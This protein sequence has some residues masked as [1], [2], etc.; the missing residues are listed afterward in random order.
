MVDDITE[1]KKMEDELKRH[2]EHLKELVEERTGKIVEGEERF[3]SVADHA[4]EA[5]ITIDNHARIVFWNRAAESIFGY[6]A[7]EATGKPITLI[8]PIWARKNNRREIRDR[9]ASDET[10]SIGKTFEVVGLRKDG[11]EFP[12]EF[13]FSVWKTRRGLFSTRI[14]RDISER[15]KVQEALRESERRYRNLVETAPEVIYTISSDGVLTSL[16]PAFE[17]LT[18]WK[19]SEWLGKPFAA[20]VHPDDLPL[21]YETFQETMRGNTPPLYELRV[22]SKSGKYLVGEFTSGPCIENGRIVGE[23]GVVRDITERKK[24]EE[25]LRASEE[26]F[27]SLFENVLVGVFQTSPEGTIITANPMLVRLFGYDSL[28]EFLA[29]D[30][31]RDLYVNPQDRKV[32]R[33]QLEEGGELHSVELALKRKDGQ[34][35]IVLESVH[36]V[37]DEHG[38]VSYYE[39]T[40]TDITERKTLEERLSALNF[41]SGKLNTSR[42]LQQIYELTLDAMERMLGFENAAFMTVER[43]RLQGVCQRGFP[44]PWLDLPLDGSKKGITVKAVNTRKPVL[45]YDVRR[46]RDYAEANPKIRSEL[47]VPVLVKDRVLGVLD[48][49]GTRAGAFDEKDLMLLQILASH[50]AIAISNLEQRKE[51]EKR[52]SQMAVLMKSSAE[53]IHSLD[54]RYRLQKIA[55]SIKEHGWRRV[56]IRAVDEASME[57]TNPQDMVTAGL[58]AKERRFL[59]NSRVPGQVWRERIGPEFERFRI[60]EFFYLPWSNPWVRRRFSQGTVASHLK[61]E[62]MVDWDPEDLLYAPLRLADGRVVGVLSVDDPTDGRKPT[63][64]SLAP[65]ELFLHQAAVAIENAQLF[66]QLTEAK[67]QIKEYADQLELKVKQRTQELVEAQHKLLKTERLATIGEI[68]A[69]VG[70]DLRNPLTGIAGAIYYLRMKSGSADEKSKEMLEIIERDV[71]YSNKIV[72]DLLDYSREIHLE[73]KEATMKAILTEA[74]SLVKIPPSVR[75]VDLTRNWPKANVDREKLKR[76]VVNLIKNAVDAMPKGGTLTVESRKA[77]EHLEVTFN[78]TGVGMSQEVIKK[79]WSPLFT[80][81]AKG[82]GF[83]LAI[84]KR[85]IEAHGGSIFVKSSIGKGTTFTITVPIEAKVEAE[86]G[87]SVWVNVPESLLSTMM[88]L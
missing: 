51:I 66:K 79:L 47:A 72:N 55:E 10:D 82:M 52:S 39:G 7:A 54:L 17:K 44:E 14:M 27:R 68:A 5:I 26:K 12:M 23:F 38:N 42:S 57:T 63:K 67:N 25:A 77:G 4:S 58:T 74:L 60:G 15:K 9:I 1:R 40:L 71:E 2:S 62:D 16:N 6:S 31:A 65:L 8:M 13:S 53:M 32:W 80:T 45:I 86:G 84:C 75:M 30:I 61:S 59:W 34:K 76:A 36:V 64:E 43:N 28:E 19:R 20:I 48:V 87:G 33:Q 29:I 73:L 85:I 11:N 22:R 37:H 3:R 18:K 49:E 88:K 56:V 78:D 46:A 24:A 83:G 41:Y 81:K 69:M 70:H 35:V 50:A 21:A